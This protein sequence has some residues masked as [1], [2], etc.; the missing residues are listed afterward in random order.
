MLAVVV[1]EFGLCSYYDEVWS[2]MCRTKK[3]AGVW[4]GNDDSRVSCAATGFCDGN[5]GCWRRAQGE[6][7][8]A[9]H[10]EGHQASAGNLSAVDGSGSKL[11]GT[12]SWLKF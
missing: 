8:I 9:C 1:E 7:L 12:I 3:G 4:L 10:E 6:V 5:G 2:L 11:K